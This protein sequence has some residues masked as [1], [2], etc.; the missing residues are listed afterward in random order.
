MGTF[1]DAKVAITFDTNDPI[2]T[3]TWRN[4]VGVPGAVGDVCP[5]DDTPDG[6]FLLALYRDVLGRP[7]D[8]PGKAFWLGRLDRGTNRQGIADQLLS[9]M[10]AHRSAG[11]RH[12]RRLPGP[13]PRS[14]WARLLGRSDATRCEPRHPAPSILG[15]DEYLRRHGG[16][17]AGFVDALYPDVFGRSADASGKAHWVATLEAGRSRSSAAGAFLYAAEGR[18]AIVRD[19]YRAY[20]GR[21]LSFTEADFWGRRLARTKDEKR[22]RSEVLGSAEYYRI[23]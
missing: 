15:S 7:P 11:P 13:Q 8:V 22:F 4:R 21:S 19:A 18:R 17:R 10:E 2:D 12:L 16:T 9:S 3:N 6:T 14:R 1:L 23:T 20:L 5:S